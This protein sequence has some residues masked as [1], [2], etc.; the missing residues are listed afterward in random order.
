MT[1]E[2]LKKYRY[3]DKLIQKDEEKLKYYKENPPSAYVGTVQSSNKEFPYQRTS[4]EVSGCEVKDRKYWK[5]KQY[6]LI[7]KLHNERAEFAQLQL[8]IDVFLTTIYDGR[9]RLI[10]EYLYR[11]GLTQQEVADKLYMDRSTVSKV[12]DQYLERCMI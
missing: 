9:D 10:F 1:K 3:L 7:E 6:E 12:V 2:K 4:V 11:D 8:E 5:Q